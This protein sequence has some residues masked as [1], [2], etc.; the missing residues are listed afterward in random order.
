VQE[1]RMD[2]T[3]PKLLN[4]SYKRHHINAKRKGVFVHRGQIREYDSM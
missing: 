2:A 4:E 1:I 3:T